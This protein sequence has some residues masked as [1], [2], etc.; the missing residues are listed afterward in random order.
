[1]ICLIWKDL[2]TIDS[3][4]WADYYPKI[5]RD[6]LWLC[7]Y[8]KMTNSSIIKTSA[9]ARPSSRHPDLQRLQ[10]EFRTHGTCMSIRL[11]CVIC[12]S[13][14]ST[15]SCWTTSAISSSRL[16]SRVKS[17][18]KS[19]TLLTNNSM[20]LPRSKK[21]MEH[22]ILDR[23]Q[24]LKPSWISLLKILSSKSGKRWITQARSETRNLY[25]GLG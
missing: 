25:T 8:G 16:Q 11:P 14:A 4:C 13:Q 21:I 12:S 23:L 9:P 3:S 7:G 19:N 24:P 22:Y 1:M 6:W 2:F 10:M 20:A 18:V 5:G 15:S 17:H